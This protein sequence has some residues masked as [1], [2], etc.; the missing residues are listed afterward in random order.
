MKLSKVLCALTLT[1]SA[2]AGIASA[3]GCGSDEDTSTFD[4]GTTQ[5]TGTGDDGSMTGFGEGGG[6]DAGDGGGDAALPANFVHTEHG[7]YAL[8]APIGDGGAG[9]P[10]VM[11][12]GDGTCSVIAGIV[13]DFRGITEDAGHPD[14]EAFAGSAQTTGLVSAA[15]GTDRKP[16]YASVCATP[17]LVNAACP[18]GQMTTSQAYFDMWYRFTNTVNL[19]YIVYIGFEANNGIETFESQHYFPLDGAGWGDPMLGDDNKPHNFHF[20]TE[21]HTSFTY[22]GGETFTFI[23]DDDVWVFINGKL[24]IDLGG[25]HGAVTGSI[26]L[27]AK[28]ADLGITVGG[29]YPLELFQAERHTV[30]STFRIDTNLAFTNCGTL[31]DDPK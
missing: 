23:G 14:F 5:D 21:L 28:A 16:V 30:S 27:D 25:V 9:D 12:Q 1:L 29:T 6:G 20:T 15:I 3:N 24:A 8:G 31:P 22:G 4:S 26:M 7:G 18:Y 11:P 13:R 17:S 2:S 19:P 10:G